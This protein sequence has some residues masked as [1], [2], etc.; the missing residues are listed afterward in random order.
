MNSTAVAWLAQLIGRYQNQALRIPRATWHEPLKP[1]PHAEYKKWKWCSR[2]AEQKPWRLAKLPPQ[3]RFALDYV[4]ALNKNQR[5]IRVELLTIS[6]IVYTLYTQ[7][8]LFQI[9]RGDLQFCSNTLY[10]FSITITKS[11]W[12]E[13]DGILPSVSHELYTYC[14]KGHF[15]TN[16]IIFLSSSKFISDKDC[17]CSLTNLKRYKDRV[18]F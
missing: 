14:D 13:L 8:I 5:M 17:Q 2:D 18:A 10:A 6:A 3:Q 15:D 16:L 11:D 9:T 12:N 1:R 4:V 7:P